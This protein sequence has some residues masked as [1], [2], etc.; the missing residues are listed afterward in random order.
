MN[1]ILTFLMILAFARGYGVIH[2]FGDSH[3]WMFR[4]HP[5]TAVYHLGGITM[6][7][8]GRDHVN[9]LNLADYHVTSEDI[10]VMVFGEIDVRGHIKK[11]AKQF[12]ITTSDVIENL[13]DRYL[14]GVEKIIQKTPVKKIIICEVIPPAKKAPNS[15]KKFPRIGSL[16]ERVQYN[17]YLNSVLESGCKT[18]GFEFFK[19]ADTYRNQ[20]QQL[21]S[22][23]T[24]D[25]VHISKK[26]RNLI[27][28]E[29]TAF[30]FALAA[31]DEQRG[32]STDQDNATNIAKRHR[33]FILVDF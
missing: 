15:N 10:V 18:K 7:R 26:Y 23:Y 11:I 28:D 12:E 31:K 8:I 17:L 19:Y 33:R 22:I 25:G 14:K 5:E 1:K 6:H 13:C 21:R 30:L 2:V 16:E 9:F 4:G 32:S 27:H 24:K 20:G 3:S 29:F